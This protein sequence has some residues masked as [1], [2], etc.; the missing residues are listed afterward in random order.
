MDVAGAAAVVGT[1]A[2]IASVLVLALQARELAKHARVANEVA[3]AE[4]N[5]ELIRRFADVHRVFTPH[6]V[7]TSSTNPPVR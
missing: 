2:V 6:C 4:T 3:S 7:R 1:A 5:R